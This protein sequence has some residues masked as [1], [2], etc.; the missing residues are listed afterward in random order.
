MD[1]IDRT[2]LPFEIGD[3]VTYAGDSEIHTIIGYFFSRGFNNYDCNYGYIIDNVITSGEYGLSN[4]CYD[5]IGRPLNVSE[6]FYVLPSSL[7]L[8]TEENMKEFTKKDLKTGMIVELNSTARYLVLG[9]TLVGIDNQLLL[10]YYNENLTLKC[11]NMD[12]IKRYTICKVYKKYVS[13]WGGGFKEGLYNDVIL[14]WERPK[15]VELSMEEIA[16][17]LGIPVNQL[18][19]KK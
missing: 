3:E 17:K 8:I 11:N 10:S 19:I 7:T 12:S 2:K 4:F 14:I 18:R 15:V 1:L 16:N 5:E 9:D 6:S 13:H